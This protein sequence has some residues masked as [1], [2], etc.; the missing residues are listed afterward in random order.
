[1]SQLLFEK[2]DKWIFDE[3]FK[4]LCSEVTRRV[5]HIKPRFYLTFSDCTTNKLTYLH[6]FLLLLHKTFRH[7]VQMYFKYRFFIFISILCLTTKEWPLKGKKIETPLKAEF[8]NHEIQKIPAN[9]KVKLNFHASKSQSWNVNGTIF[10]TQWT[11]HKVLSGRSQS[12]FSI[13]GA[14]PGI[15][16]CQIIQSTN[17][18]RKVKYLLKKSFPQ[19]RFHA[20]KP[21]EQFG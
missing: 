14:H 8:Y 19:I 2:G 6:K 21:G 9:I 17:W 1:M 18:K 4:S 7:Y 15:C 11:W 3:F 5:L 13:F 10:I 20:L 12:K 16:N